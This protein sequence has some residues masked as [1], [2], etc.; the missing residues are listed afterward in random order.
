MGQSSHYM[1]EVGPFAFYLEGSFD[2]YNH[3]IV[4]SLVAHLVVQGV[5]V[6]LTPR[7]GCLGNLCRV[8]DFV[9]L[10]VIGAIGEMRRC[11]EK[12]ELAISLYGRGGV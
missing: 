1:E 4:S 9:S 8:G 12:C 6:H 5:S 2:D 10:C 11:E 7:S 3:E